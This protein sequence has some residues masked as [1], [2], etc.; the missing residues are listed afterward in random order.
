[1]RRTQRPAPPSPAKGGRRGAVTVPPPREVR[2]FVASPSD[3]QFERMRL[4][5]VVKRMNT[6]FAPAAR[7]ACYRW[8]ENFYT[9]GPG[10]QDQIPEPADYDIVI[11][12]LGSRLG[13]E[14]PESFPRRLPDGS[15]YASG[16]AYELLSSLAAADQRSRPDIYVF[17]KS[18]EPVF[19]L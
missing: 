16:T 10:Y 19:G 17:R 15:P 11:A 1:M 9:A 14:L 12:I 13:S 6:A 8:E 2:L 4:D 18:V 7:F 5:K 3:V